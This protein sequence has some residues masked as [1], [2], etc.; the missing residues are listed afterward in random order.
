MHTKF[1]IWRKSTRSSGGDNCVEVSFA[2]DGSVGVRDSKNR[3]GAILEFTATEWDSF[4][5]GVRAGE[6]NR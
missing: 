3:D 2:Q 4:L 6:F 1:E 5:G